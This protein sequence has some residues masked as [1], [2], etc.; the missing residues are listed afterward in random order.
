MTV[1]YLDIV[2]D[3]DEVVGRD[4]RRNVH[5]N[6]QIHRGVHVVVVNGHGQVLI[7]RRSMLKDYCPGLLDMSVGAQVGS[8]ET[9]EEAAA[10]ELREELG[11]H[12]GP[13]RFLAGY[14]AYSVRQREKRRIFI[15]ECD[16][17]FF[18]DPAE[19]ESVQF[20][21]GGDLPGML[22]AEQF[23]EGCRRSVGIYLGLLAGGGP[24][25]PDRV[26]PASA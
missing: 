18:P 8:G 24:G 2:N 22:A 15:H 14:D 25:E 3:D 17:P 13:L 21:A 10:R 23:T 19:V 9:Y 12:D 6:Y 16:G 26:N 11:C 4:T 5:D 20:V 1:E 7:Q